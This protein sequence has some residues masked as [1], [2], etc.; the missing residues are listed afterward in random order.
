MSHTSLLL[1]LAVLAAGWA[2]ATDYHVAPS[3]DDGGPGTE[4]RPFRTIQRAADAMAPGDACI[5]REGVYR[6]TVR[7]ARSGEVGKPL[8]FLAR[9]GDVVVLNGAEPIQ[10][11]WSLHEGSIYKTAAEGSFEQIFVDGEMMIEARWPNARFGQM[12]DRGVWAKAGRGSRYGKMVDPALAKTGLDWT[13]ALATLNVAHQFFTWSRPVRQHAKGSDTFEYDKDFPG[14][15]SY[16][17][18]TTPW[19]DDLYYL[20]GKLG[21]LDSPTEWFLDAESRT[22]YLWCPDGQ[23]PAG[24]IVE[25][26]R[27]DYAFD[28]EAREHVEI[29][30]FHFFAA[31]FRLERCRDCVV[32]GCHLR[33]PTFQR[34]IPEMENPRGTSVKTYVAGSHNAVR[35]CSL[36]HSPASG[37]TVLGDHN[38]VEDNL[39]HNVC[40]NGCLTYA[41]ISL[42]PLGPREPPAEEAKYREAASCGSVLRRNTVF[43]AGNVCIHVGGMPGIVVELCH[44]HSG[45]RAS[46]D[47]SLLYTQ[48]PHIFG[49]VFRY[50]WVHDCHA[51]QIALGIRGDDQTRGLTVHHNVVWNCDWDGIVLKGDHNRCYNN[52]CFGNRQSDILVFSA[53]EPH[54]PWRGQWPLLKVQNRNTEVANNCAQAITAARGRK[55]GPVGGRSE[56]NYTGQEPM[57]ADLPE[58]DFRPREGSPLIAAGRAIPGITDGFVGKAPDIGAYEH[59]GERWV[60]GCRNGVWLA[61]RGDRLVV[62]LLMPVPGAVTLSVVAE[63][64]AISSGPT[65]GFTPKD[66]MRPKEVRFEATAKGDEPIALVVSA[67]GLGSLRI[68]DVRR[69]D[70]SA[71]ARHWFP[72]GSTLGTAGIAPRRG[73]KRP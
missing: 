27:R 48:L 41:G 8:R 38:V 71:G 65:L 70:P 21:A 26:K 22:L 36:A 68:P 7:P 10:G 67:D 13:G 55:A 11:A 63:G 66:W 18:K 45:G 29:V 62:S 72:Q 56:N 4:R 57:L 59:G 14:I 6:E 9:P 37:L 73:P 52:T 12:L 69:T 30:G 47:V 58:L 20:S 40:W 24:H 42:G 17:D 44:I 5:V 1:A 2:N 64:A 43:D 46:K 60:P 15:T 49:T 34:T 32:E 54:K 31:T 53:P 39:I 16:A 3:G 25:A 51:P 28:L 50:N 35:H 33:F 23:S 61:P 19:E